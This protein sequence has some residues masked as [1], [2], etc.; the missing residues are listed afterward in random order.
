MAKLYILIGIPGSGKSTLAAQMSKDNADLQIISSDG[1]RVEM[2]LP[3][4]K[5]NNHIIFKEMHRRLEVAL[6][7]GFVVVLDATNLEAQYREYPMRIAR[8]C[9]ATVI[10]KVLNT[11]YE[12]CVKRNSRRNRKAKVS[13]E[14]LR[15][16]QIKLERTMQNL[17]GFDE[18]DYTS[19][20]P[21]GKQ[22]LSEK[23]ISNVV[24]IPLNKLD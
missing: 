14:T 2:N 4:D 15:V 10:A 8:S 3:Y 11:D 1:V 18:V 19:P 20:R 24:P 17:D 7:R 16:M 6:K 12:V 13:D 21:T 5:F 23:P 22:S 9:G